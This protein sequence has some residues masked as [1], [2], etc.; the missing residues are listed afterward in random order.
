MP[1][2]EATEDAVGLSGNPG[3]AGAAASG[4]HPSPV[5]RS[6]G[7]ATSGVA[8]GF[9][10]RLWLIGPAALYCVLRLPSFFEPHWYTDEAGYVA[11]A[12]SMLQG[13]TLYTQI[14]N[15]KPP[16]HL[17][18]VALVIKFLG[19]SEAALHSLTFVSG[20]LTLAAVA[21]ACDRV[22]G[23]RRTAIALLVAAVLLG[24][25]ILDAEL[26]L[27]E[28]LLIAPVTW[29]G[30]ILL[31]RFAAPDER[32]WPR[33]PIAVGALV[34]VAIAY[35]QTAVAEACAFGFI[36]LVTSRGNWRR[37]AAYAI[38][39]SALTVAWLIPTV[40]SAGLSTASYALVGFYVH[41]TQGNFAGTAGL[42]LH[43]VPIVVAFSLLVLCAWFRRHDRDPTW[44]LWFWAGAALL[45]PSIARQ[46]YPHYLLPSAVP[47]AM[48]I[49]SLRPLRS[50]GVSLTQRLTAAGLIAGTAL[51]LPA[52]A[53][54]GFNWIPWPGISD[55]SLATYYGGAVLVAT[56]AQSDQ[57]WENEFDL[58]VGEDR[59]AA[60]WITGHGLQGTSAVIWSADAWL[61]SIS[62]F[63]VLMPT[64]P[65]YNDAPLLGGWDAT[66]QRV[67]SLD[68]VVVV[69]EG[70]TIASYPQIEPLLA[71]SYRACEQ[72]GS[73]IVWVRDDVAQ[74]LLG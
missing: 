73:E 46:P 74:A 23:R 51:V 18:T 54:T 29:A 36:L 41:F 53:V 63:T 22:L 1:G 28:S 70:T 11:T 5:S 72:N 50:R 56:G 19:T 2:A 39:V 10:R 60:D 33:W 12:R 67:A 37:F 62:D 8:G 24:T 65:I 31:R 16:L 32:D 34:A 61:Y 66:A 38:T 21:Y 55:L 69:T 35:Q 20:L 14:W 40:L 47:V 7:P 26:L 52:A 30:A 45:V 4:R 3:A 71:S 13:K 44:A 25:P 43:L 6:D 27:P 48:A 58:R 64:P 59:A 42:L 9:R 49:C 15:N 17:W 57:S 68:P